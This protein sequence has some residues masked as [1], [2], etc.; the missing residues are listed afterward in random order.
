LSVALP[1]Q[2]SIP[3][4]L[5][6]CRWPIIQLIRGYEVRLGKMLQPLPISPQDILTP[7][8]KAL[9]VQWDG[10][11]VHDLPEMYCARAEAGRYEVRAGDLLVCEGG[12]VGRCATLRDTIR[13]GIIIQNS[14]HRVRPRPGFSSGYLL[15]AL[16]AIHGSGWLDVLCNRATIGHLTREKLAALSIPAPPLPEQRAI[17]AFLDHETTL[18]DQLVEKK[19]TLIQLLRE[20]FRAAANAAFPAKPEDGSSRPNSRAASPTSLPEGWQNVELRRLGCDVGPGP[21]GTLLH[22]GDYV[23]RG[24][25]LV[26]PVHIV[27]GRIVPEDAASVDTATRDRLFAYS[28]RE[29]D[30]LIGRRGELGRTATVTP[31]EVG[32]LC[33]TDTLRIRFRHPLIESDYVRFYLDFVAR[34]YFDQN[35]MAATMSNLN[36]RTLLSMPIVVPPLK[37]QQAIVERCMGLKANFERYSKI[38]GDQIDSLLGRRQALITAT[39]TG[40]IAVA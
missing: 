14:L 10:I 16:S 25:P 26:N 39:V 33:G 29:G 12:E 36:S 20:R 40:R 32:W 6:G 8:L 11:A 13:P 18:I 34:P 1:V 21:F 17:A 28:L 15:Y 19:Q 7:Y 2:E 24:W 27:D 37:E 30:V 23:D 5:Q 22:S 35:S 4:Y 3:P 9:H 31:R 38:L